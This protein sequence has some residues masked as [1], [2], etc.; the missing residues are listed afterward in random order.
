MFRKALKKFAKIPAEDAW[1]SLDAATG[2]VSQGIPTDEEIQSSNVPLIPKEVSFIMSVDNDVLFVK[3][4]LKYVSFLSHEG[5]IGVGPG[6]PMELYKVL[7]GPVELH[8]GPEK[9]ERFFT[10]GGFMFTQEA[11]IAALTTHEFLRVSD[12]DPNL[13]RIEMQKLK[14]QLKARDQKA[15]VEAWIKIEVLER[16]ETYLE[17]YEE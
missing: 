10:S 8:Y 5:K 6:H 13:C 17:E 3:E 7:A 1:K 11:G 4:K 15:R 14:Q 12:L 2:D 9:I 16:F